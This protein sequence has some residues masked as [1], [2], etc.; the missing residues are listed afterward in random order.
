MAH[1]GHVFLKV[2]NY[3]QTCSICDRWIV[4]TNGVQ[5]GWCG[6]ACHTNC[7]PATTECTAKGK[8]ERMAEVLLEK[9][10]KRALCTVTGPVVDLSFEKIGDCGIGIICDKLSITTDISTLNLDGNRITD[11]GFSDIVKLLQVKNVSLLSVASNQLLAPSLSMLSALFAKT[12]SQITITHLNLS[13]ND[14]S[15]SDV[16]EFCRALSDPKQRSLTSLNMCFCGLSSESMLEILTT[17]G[18]KLNTLDLSGNVVTSGKGFLTELTAALS[19]STKLV[20]FHLRGSTNGRIGDEGAVCFGQLLKK[21]QCRLTSLN[22]SENGISDDGI[23]ALSQG[24]Y[25]NSDLRTLDLS[26]NPFGDRV[27]GVLSQCIAHKNKLSTLDVSKVALSTD[28]ISVLTNLQL[29]VR[30]D[31]GMEANQQNRIAT[32]SDHNQRTTW[33][34]WCSG[35]YQSEEHTVIKRK[36]IRSLFQCRGCGQISAKCSIQSCN[37]MAN[38]HH[39][40]ANWFC[41]VHSQSWRLLLKRESDKTGEVVKWGKKPKPIT[42]W[43]SWCLLLTLHQIRKM[44]VVN[45]SCYTCQSCSNF[46]FKC[47]VC[48]EG[49]ARGN[50][51]TSCVRCAKHIQGWLTSTNDISK[52]LSQWNIK[53][54]WCSWCVELSDHTLQYRGLFRN[55]YKCTYCKQ[56]TTT[57]LRCDSGMSCGSLL[58]SQ[59]GYVFAASFRQQWNLHS[60]GKHLVF[61]GESQR[62]LK[63]DLIRQSNHKTLAQ[64]SGLIRPFLLLVAMGPSARVNAGLLLG[65]SL[66]KCACFGD[67]HSE[68][69]FIITKGM[70]PGCL[71]ASEKLNVIMSQTIQ[72]VA[73]LR[74]IAD[75]YSP[76]LGDSITNSEDGEVLLLRIIAEIKLKSMSDDEI[77]K[78]TELSESNDH[79]IEELRRRLSRVGIVDQKIVIFSLVCIFSLKSDV[80]ANSSPVRSANTP[81]IGMLINDRICQQDGSSTSRSSFASPSNL[82]SAAFFVATPL[83]V[84]FLAACWIKSSLTSSPLTLMSLVSALLTQRLLLAA[85]GINI[86]EFS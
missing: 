65:V 24:L 59:C 57:C 17:V 12:P 23:L 75:A 32:S 51:E 69:W 14:F 30:Y 31:S 2:P 86:K 3:F 67:S 13:H 45:S 47:T 58:C 26:H 42:R 64:Q 15:N 37:S 41:A 56:R 70:L 53:G 27:V 63:D 85:E 33:Y 49:M 79:H 11:E 61:S 73:V 36:L 43:C 68:S 1:G 29:T 10:L 16:A 77:N 21:S 9:R 48:H 60:E 46:T 76:C 78:F 81:N 25:L 39:T 82:A 35:C 34:G 54:R 7:V 40:G 18:P 80:Q 71:T 8:E 74:R 28:S 55:T 38:Y 50:G 22:I 44:N 83:S 84:P 4:L 52:T 62:P 5:C 72:W 66:P 20:D 19:K 6:L